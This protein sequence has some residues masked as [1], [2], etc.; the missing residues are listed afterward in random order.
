MVRNCRKQISNIEKG[1]RCFTAEPPSESGGRNATESDRNRR[2]GLLLR[3]F[4]GG[5][6]IGFLHSCQ[7]QDEKD[8][9]Q[10]DV[11]YRSLGDRS[12]DQEQERRSKEEIAGSKVLL[13]R[14]SLLYCV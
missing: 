2:I 5:L 4:F 7:A 8:S 14:L 3:L 10:T 13:T 12:H 6:L 1:S 9:A 11:E